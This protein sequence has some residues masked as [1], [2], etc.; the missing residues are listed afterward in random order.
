MKIYKEKFGS[1]IERS[2][3]GI[4][5]G[6]TL[7]DNDDGAAAVNKVWITVIVVISILSIAV[8]YFTSLSIAVVN[9]LAAVWGVFT[10]LTLLFYVPQ[11][12]LL[13]WIGGVIGVGGTDLAGLSNA[14]GKLTSA[15]GK[16]VTAVNASLEGAWKIHPISIYIFLVLMLLCLI[17]AYKSS[18]S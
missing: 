14:I 10:G 8:C 5:G 12:I 9:V 3:E 4:F 13:T 7:A 17:P 1:L 2:V 11:K 6:A 15:V 16:L 18:D